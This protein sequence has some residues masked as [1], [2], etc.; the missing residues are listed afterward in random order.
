MVLAT[1]AALGTPA[2]AAA[3]PSVASGPDWDA[4]AA[5]ESDGDWQANTGN[6]HYGGLQFT[7]SSWT[8]AGQNR[9]AG[10]WRTGPASCR[11]STAFSCHSTS[12]PASLAV[13]RGSRAPGTDSNDRAARYGSEMA[14]GAASQPPPRDL[15]HELPLQR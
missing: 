6:G 7:Q 5:C 14:T 3:S 11:R 9:F 2:Q 13:S 10:S 8:A 15:V 1:A 12:G 4:I